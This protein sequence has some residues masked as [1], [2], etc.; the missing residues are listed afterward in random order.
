MSSS[1][2]TT[3]SA[4]GSATAS[5]TDLATGASVAAINDPDTLTTGEK[6]QIILDY[7]AIT[8]E[9]AD[10]VA[11]ANAYS[12][13]HATYD[14]AYSALLSYLS[15][16][17]SPTAWNSLSG[18]TSLGTGN[19][20]ALWN[21]K[22][23]AVKNAA[24]D[25]RNAIAVGTAQN[26]ITTAATDATNKANA[27][28]LASQPHQV[29]WAYASKPA[30]PD[31]AYPAGYYAIT[32]DARTVQV[33]AAG[34]AWADV[35]VAATGLFGKLISSQLTV[36]NLDNLIP[37]GTSDQTPPP[38]GWPAGSFE[39]AWLDYSGP[40]AYSGNYARAVYHTNGNYDGTEVARI[41]C[42]AGDKYYMECMAKSQAPGS[43]LINC[44][45]LD[46]ANNAVGWGSP[47]WANSTT[48]T[49]AMSTG[50]APAGAVLMVIYIEV[51]TSQPS[52]WYWFDNL[53]AR[54][55]ADASMLV[56]GT[57]QALV[58]RVPLLYSVDLRSG[59]DENGYH[60]GTAI[61][62]PIGFRI[63]A[64]PFPT[65]YIGG[66]TDSTCMMELGGSANFG[67]YKVAT[68]NSRIQPVNR[69]ING[70]FY[71]D[72]NGWSTSGAN[73]PTYQAASAT[74]G[75]G[76]AAQYF[77]GGFGYTKA[78]NLTQSFSMPQPFSGQTVSLAYKTGYY[79]NGANSGSDV[80]TIQVYILN[81]S[82]GTET[83]LAT[84]TYS[85]ANVA[86]A[87]TARSVDITSYVS[88]GGQFSIRFA[89]TVNDSHGA[90]SFTNGVYVDEVTVI[91]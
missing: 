46:A 20:V 69:I 17:T 75:T 3:S 22:W 47:T 15:T 28:Q 50:T 65:T 62:A 48:Y 34:T 7:N 59:S 87:W 90:G 42:A 30:L 56:D 35:L 71:T 12:V 40:N 91:A 6:P 89:M 60:A 4:S 38:G 67:G 33:N 13:S 88:A 21:P 57:L 8:G 77:V 80:C 1:P 19:R 76:S 68:V 10:L 25:L 66:A 79:G 55:M 58:A 18:T 73:P 41:P 5:S 11:K 84:H 52:G 31:P 9:N 29:A 2:W 63:S 85:N 70:Y 32:T 74:S 45:F 83:L 86:L 26:A 39:A 82:T 49:K 64:N 81:Q 36:T 37:N 72:L 27:A 78:G 23:A 44:Y 54:R 53:Y 24:A 51:D 16:L 61:S 14:T 43:Q